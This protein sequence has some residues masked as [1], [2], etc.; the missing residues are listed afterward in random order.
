MHHLPQRVV[1]RSAFII[2]R[3]ARADIFIQQGV[4]VPDGVKCCIFHLKDN[5]LR[6]GHEV[7]TSKLKKKIPEFNQSEITDLDLLSNVGEKYCNV[8]LTHLI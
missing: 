3:S 1:Q 6:A 7:E 4:L 5:H 2:P 8:A